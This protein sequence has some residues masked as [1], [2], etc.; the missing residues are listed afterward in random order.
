MKHLWSII[1]NRLIVDEATN[2]ATLVDV[3]EE[4]KIKKDFLNN[5]KEIILPFNLV[6]LWNIENKKDYNKE[7]KTVIEFYNPNGNKLND[8]SFNFTVPLSDKK[9][10]R[11]VINFNKFILDG[12]GVYN[13]K[14][15]QDNKTISELPLEIKLV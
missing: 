14:I 9:R 4:I 6:S 15:K 11:T 2:N 13:I 8:F 1:C 3:L 7:I 10:V 5:N 12:S